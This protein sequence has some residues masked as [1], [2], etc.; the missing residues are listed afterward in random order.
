MPSKLKYR[1]AHFVLNLIS[2]PLFLCKMQRNTHAA[3]GVVCVCVCV[4]VSEECSIS[5]KSWADLNRICVI[6]EIKVVGDFINPPSMPLADPPDTIQPSPAVCVSV[7]V[8]VCVCASDR[9]LFA[10]TL[11]LCQFVRLNY[12]LCFGLACAE[13]PSHPPFYVNLNLSVIR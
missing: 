2:G 1:H 9:K 10:Y 4:W 12:S 13:L 6:R 8:C 5:E 3:D 11:Q 7:C